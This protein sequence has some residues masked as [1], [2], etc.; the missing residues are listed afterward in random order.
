MYTCR[1]TCY[2]FAIFLLFWQFVGESCLPTAFSHVITMANFIHS[3]ITLLPVVL[4]PDDDSLHTPVTPVDVPSGLSSPTSSNAPSTTPQS[5]P[6]SVPAAPQFMWTVEWTV[7]LI[8]VYRENKEKFQDVNWK[9]KALWKY[10]T[11]ELGRKGRAGPNPTQAQ[12]EGKWKTPIAS[13]KRTRDHNNKSGNNR[14]ECAFQTQMDDVLGDCAS[15]SPK[16]IRNLLFVWQYMYMRVT[17]MQI[18]DVE[19]QKWL[20]T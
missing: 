19:V 17:F 2:H 20:S 6:A 3:G 13:Y 14:K 12:T 9:K 18:S 16:V 4:P 1:S 7:L 5:S 15:V 11:E 8:A 10:I